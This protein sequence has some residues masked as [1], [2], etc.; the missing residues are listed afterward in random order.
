MVRPFL[1]SPNFISHTEAGRCV[2]PHWPRPVDLK[3]SWVYI[4]SASFFP[5]D[6]GQRQKCSWVVLIGVCVVLRQ[7]LLLIC[8]YRAV[9]CK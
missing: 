7:L 9:Y 3:M 6:S 5:G 4:S 2:P 8:F 1:L